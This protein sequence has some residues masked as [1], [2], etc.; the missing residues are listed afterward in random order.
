MDRQA[1][2]PSYCSFDVPASGLDSSFNALTA[3]GRD[4]LAVEDENGHL[5]VA[6]KPHT[7]KEEGKR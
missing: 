3:C 7:A 5:D 6:R 2:H 1:I 4:S